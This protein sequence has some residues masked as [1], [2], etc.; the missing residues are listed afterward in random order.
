MGRV[1]GHPAPGVLAE[2]LLGGGGELRSGVQDDG[3]QVEVDALEDGRQG[4]HRDAVL[5]DG[6]PEAG[7]AVLQVREH[8]LVGVGRVR[9]GMALAHVPPGESGALGPASA[10]ERREAGQAGVGRRVVGGVEGTGAES[11]LDIGGE[12]FLGQRAYG[13]RCA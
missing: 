4:L 3:R 8:G 7:D 6:Q 1:G 10:H 9:V 5:A 2:Q 12:G 13:V 11:V